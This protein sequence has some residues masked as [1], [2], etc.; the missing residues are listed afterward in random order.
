MAR[1]ESIQK[2]IKESFGDNLNAR[3]LWALV[4]LSK[5]V[6]K[7]CRSNAA[8]NNSL[9]RMFP[10]ASFRQVTKTRPAPR[11]LGDSLTYPGLEI[12]IKSTGETTTDEESED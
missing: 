7:F 1:E 4:R 8:L 3:Q 12:S 9:N 6:R 10:H 11:F 2:A 5:H